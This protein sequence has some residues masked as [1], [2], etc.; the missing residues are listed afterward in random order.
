MSAIDCFISDHELGNFAT[1]LCGSGFDIRQDPNPFTNGIQVRRN[2]H[3]MGIIWNKAWKR[4]TVDSRL[5]DLL[6]R[7]L[8]VR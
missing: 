7:Y 3:W 5:K 6:E 4:Y 8:E 1:F 2:G